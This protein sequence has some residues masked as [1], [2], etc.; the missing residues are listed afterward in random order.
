MGIDVLEPVP[1]P[2]VPYELSDPFILVHEA[3]VPITAERAQIDTTHRH[4]GFDN[5]WYILSGSARTGHSTVPD[6][7]FERARLEAGDL[8]KIRTGRGVYHAEN[9]GEDELSEGKT[10]EFHSVLFWV[11]L[12]RRD[13]DVQPVAQLVR[14]EELPTHGGRAIV[15]TLVGPGSPVELGTPARILDVALP[16]GGA[17]KQP[18]PAE[19]NTFVWM[20]E[21]VCEHRLQQE[22]HGQVSDRGARTRC[23]AYRR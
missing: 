4:R 20:L 1:G 18:I 22:T 8:L 7:A 6:G 5:L 10:G 16:T 15:R 2:N 13:K 9:I 19:F 21:G 12:A 3:K 14:A 23:C 11:N 17:F